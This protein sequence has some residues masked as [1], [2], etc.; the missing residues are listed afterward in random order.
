MPSPA[1]WRAPS[2]SYGADF[3]SKDLFQA[4]QPIEEVAR[5]GHDAPRFRRSQ[6]G[7]PRRPAHGAASLGGG[8]AARRGPGRPK[9]QPGGVPDQP[10]LPR[11]AP[12]LPHDSPASSR[13]SSPATA[14]CTATRSSDGAASFGRPPAPGDAPGRRA[15]RA[16]VRGGDRSPA[17]EGYCEAMRSGLHAALAVAADLAGI[18]LPKLPREMAFGALLA[19]ATDPATVDYQPMHANFGIMEP[20]VP[21]VRNKRERIRR[22]RRAERRGAR[23]LPERAR[24][25]RPRVAPAR[26][27]RRF[28]PQPGRRG[29]AVDRSRPGDARG[30]GLRFCS[31]GR[32]RGFL[33]RPARGD[34]T[35]RRTRCAPTASTSR[36]TRAGRAARRS[37][38]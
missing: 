29:C 17:P 3:E 25:L 27:A 30:A 24:S 6:A 19:W 9:L 34:P 1:R 15:A 23:G 31:R 38:R 36:T 10:H 33:R 28:P 12:R 35:R 5:A 7:G 11:A 2:A 8:A 14:S 4:C 32:H 26:R 16:C 37:T 22:L 13:R 20:L 18:A 21:P